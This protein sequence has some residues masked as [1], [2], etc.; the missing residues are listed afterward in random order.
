MWSAGSKLV[1]PVDRVT[2]EENSEQMEDG[3]E[4]RG[5]MLFHVGHDGEISSVAGPGGIS[6]L[7]L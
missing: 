2:V 4:V 1:R 3:D 7:F 5:Q 6:A